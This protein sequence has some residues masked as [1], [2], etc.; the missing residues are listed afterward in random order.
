MRIG[1]HQ[2]V[3]V[4]FLALGLTVPLAP[5]PVSVAA[6]VRA[7]QPALCSPVPQAAT[8]QHRPPPPAAPIEVA[9]VDQAGYPAGAPKV[10]EVMSGL[11]KPPSRRW[12]LVR[13]TPCQVAASGQLTDGLGSWNRGYL[14]VWRV[15]F[16]K[17]HRPGSYRLQ[18]QMGRSVTSAS[19]WF[20]IGPGASLYRQPLANALSFYQ[21]ER[22]GPDFI[23]SALR[24]APAHV[25]DVRAMTYRTPPMNGNGQF[26]GSL[27]PYRTGTVINA[28]GGWFDAGDYLKF[29]QTTSYAVAALLQGIESFPAEMG[30][31][32]Q[33][34]FTGEA[35][36]GLDFLQRMW[37]ERTR[38]LYYQVGIGE[39]N[40][41]FTGDHDIWR[42]PQADDHY[43]AGK[44]SDRYI[45]HPP[46][47]RAGRPG[48]PVSPNLAG[49][50]AADFALC[51]R[52]FR[53]ASPAYANGCLRSAET[54]YSFA[55]THW[56]GH[57]L[58]AA[59]YDFYPETTWRDD[60]MLGATEL[61]L[62]LHA[63]GP[64][65]PSGLPVRSASSYLRQAAM[66]AHEFTTSGQATADTLNLYDVSGLA[67][68]ELYQA[69]GLEH[70][71]GL[72]IGQR[73]LL[74][75]LHAQLDA[76]MRVAARD[77]FRFGFAWN[78][79]D[80]AAHG[81][82]LTV[83]ASEYDALAHRPAFAGRAQGW[84]DNILGA[85]AWGTSFIVGDG[86]TYPHCM[87]HQV[88]NLA[89]SLTGRPPVLAGATVEGPNSY[90]ATGFVAPMRACN[91]WSPSGVPFS[92]F[93][94]HG[95]VYSDNVQ[96]FSTVEPAIDLTALTPMAFA[97]REA[98]A[99]GGRIPPA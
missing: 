76:A 9:R 47:F 81:A 65:L 73:G 12:L 49:R 64:A 70:G 37:N 53:T 87:Q 45:R 39:A 97:W 78:Q 16:T 8:T 58:T 90:A 77:P 66:W 44:A 67:Y 50:L 5:A 28:A 38:T 6:A 32:G 55:G 21:N 75:A 14:S 22:D 82:G 80:T 7:G 71:S 96:S 13:R 18:V 24:T 41:H 62:A 54:V 99:R 29:V 36:F 1:G 56:H 48:A 94:G 25:N 72:A 43:G 46:V 69:I 74:A 19:P 84:L 26:K 31:H 98:M 85:N 93:N 27:A 4:A 88:A 59:P 42:L 63:A 23:R 79:W 68:Y 40:S 83:L 51:Y 52:V 89:G 3:L 60:M 34:N 95:A 61:S 33:V 20:R 15:N 57:L 11:R 86:A 30:T 91:A 10:G 92:D 2:A 17:V 35:K